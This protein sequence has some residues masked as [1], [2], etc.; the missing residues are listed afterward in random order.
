MDDRKIIHA[1][2][3]RQGF[4]AATCKLRF[5]DSHAVVRHLFANDHALI[6]TMPRDAM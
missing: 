2:G 6:A 4:I 1:S 5:Y 3:V